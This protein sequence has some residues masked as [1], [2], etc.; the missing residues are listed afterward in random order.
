MRRGEFRMTQLTIWIG[1]IE[2]SWPDADAAEALGPAF[3]NVNTWASSPEEISQK[4]CSRGRYRIFK[5]WIQQ[6]V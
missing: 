6:A 2:L 1:A 5:R 3:T 4:V